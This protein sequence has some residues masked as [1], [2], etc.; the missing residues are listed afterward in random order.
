MKTKIQEI[1]KKTQNAYNE[2]TD[3]T[4]TTTRKLPWRAVDRQIEPM[5]DRQTN[6]LIS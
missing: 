2:N 4:L 6:P 5:T 3:K 1:Q